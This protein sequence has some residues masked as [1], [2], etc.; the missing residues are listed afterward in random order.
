MTLSTEWQRR[1]MIKHVLCRNKHTSH[2]VVFITSFFHLNKG[3]WLFWGSSKVIFVKISQNF[4]KSPVKICLVS[5]ISV[6]SLW[7]VWF[8]CYSAR[9]QILRI[10]F[11]SVFSSFF[12]FLQVY[13]WAASC[14]VIRGLKTCNMPPDEGQQTTL[15]L[16]VGCRKY[17]FI[18]MIEKLVKLEVIRMFNDWEVQLK[19]PSRG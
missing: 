9:R 2:L 15:L 7:H 12:S 10:F 4:I 11:F 6:H 3:F 14:D 17:W 1:H 5:Q 18:N 16:G 8:R 13:H 19:I